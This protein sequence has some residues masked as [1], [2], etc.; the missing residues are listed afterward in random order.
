MYSISNA[1]CPICGG[2]KKAI[3]TQYFH[4][5]G[6]ESRLEDWTYIPAPNEWIEEGYCTECGTK[7][8]HPRSRI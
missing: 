7:F 8:I 3:V 5:V 2:S 6:S 4:G 1:H